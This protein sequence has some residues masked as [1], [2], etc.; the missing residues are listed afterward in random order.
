MSDEIA[1]TYLS[2]IYE[3]EELPG[4]C[5]KLPIL[6]VEQLELLDY[7][8]AVHGPFEYNPELA[9]VVRRVKVDRPRFLAYKALI[10]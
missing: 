10:A 5:F 1:E 8:P 2:D 6:E 7:N 9:P 3:K 4:V